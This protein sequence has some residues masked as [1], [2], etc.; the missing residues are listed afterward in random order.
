MMIPFNGIDWP[1][2]RRIL[3]A[4]VQPKG[5]K[6]RQAVKWISEN[7]KEDEK[8]PIYRLIQDA[9]LRFTL[10]PKEEDFLRS[11]YEEDSD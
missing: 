2:K 11:F 10:S 1:L 9:S 7:L 3:M 5:E 8:R 6:V 4:T